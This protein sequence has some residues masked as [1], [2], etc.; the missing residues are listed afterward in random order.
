[1]GSGLHWILFLLENIRKEQKCHVSRYQNLKIRIG[2]EGETEYQ[3]EEQH[4]SEAEP[5]CV[6][7]CQLLLEQLKGAET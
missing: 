4:F 7:C 2:N 3:K 5:C 6:S 1:M